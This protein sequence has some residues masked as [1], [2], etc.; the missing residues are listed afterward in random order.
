MLILRRSLC[1][2]I[3]TNCLHS[4]A[5][6]AAL[7]DGLRGYWTFNGTA[8]DS[9][10]NGRNLSTFGSAS[11]GSGLFGQA[12]VLPGNNSSYAQQAANDTAFDLGSGDFTIQL[13][14][15]FT[16][17]SREQTL[18]EKFTGSS[19]PGWTLTT[20]GGNSLQFYAGVTTLTAS[21]AL[22][23]GVWHTVV[24]RR[25]GTAFTMYYDGSLVASNSSASAIS[26]SA[27]P[28]LIGKRNSGDGRDFS[29]NGTLDEVAVWN[30]ALSAA[31]IGEVWNGGSGVPVISPTPT[32]TSTA[33]HTPTATPSETP[34]I[35][36]THSP[37]DTPT[38][39]PSRT[40]SETATTTATP[41]ETPTETPTSSPSL[42]PTQTES[43][44]PTST[45]PLACPLLP[46]TPCR[47]AAST[48]SKISVSLRT[49]DPS[50]NKLTWAWK[51]QSTTLAELASPT[52]TTDYRVCIYD[53]ANTLLFNLPLAAGGTC[54]DK[55]C[56][57]PGRLGFSYKNK[58]TNADGVGA[59]AIKSGSDGKA[60]AKV[61]AKGASLDMPTIPLLAPVTAQ[62]INSTNTV[63]WTAT[64]NT[65]TTDAMDTEKWKSK[66]D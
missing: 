45:P 37:T 52:S 32:P 31:E 11:F 48:K 30:R 9:S 12:L 16:S 56:W 53:A 65:A 6:H 41:S 43:P 57:K 55:P 49:G 38:E 50:K 40:P 33:T 3:L 10:G 60:S 35:T 18:I 62:I 42:T 19:G 61:K 8:A 44:T 21:A 17:A 1:L 59:F 58:A 14:V 63:C 22:T 36:P 29:L 24:V 7:S 23:T 47:D 20:P 34:T 64:F 51:G 66:N 26:A 13:W 25:S 4:A 54:D 46:R 2:L 27:N 15:K 5:A 39:T 28:I